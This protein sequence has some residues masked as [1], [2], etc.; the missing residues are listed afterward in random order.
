MTAAPE[1]GDLVERLGL[2]LDRAVRDLGKAGEP[3]A[4]ARIAAEA[5]WLVREPAPACAR[6]L[7]ATLHYLTLGKPART[8]D[9]KETR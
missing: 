8:S 7:N 6:R 5:W 9:T 2:L 1:P 3:D 4:A